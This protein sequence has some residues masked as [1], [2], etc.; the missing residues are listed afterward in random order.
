MCVC[1]KVVSGVV[2]VCR[3]DPVIVGAAVCVCVC[4]V[5]R[6]AERKE[7]N[8]FLCVCVCW[9]PDWFCFRLY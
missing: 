3:L 6:D 8:Q 1:V 5:I 2:S 7:H 4:D 9:L